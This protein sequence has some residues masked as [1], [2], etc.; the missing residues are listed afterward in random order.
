[1]PV[2]LIMTGLSPVSLYVV[3]ASASLEDAIIRRLLN[4]PKDFPKGFPQ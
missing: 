2:E 4:V 3:I 1:M